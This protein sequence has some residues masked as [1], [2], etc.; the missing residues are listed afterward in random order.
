MKSLGKLLMVMIMFPSPPDDASNDI[1]VSIVQDKHGVEQ[2]LATGQQYSNINKR[3]ASPCEQFTTNL[4]K[5][6]RVHTGTYPKV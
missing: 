1:Y 5:R 4:C 6:S 2:I 3:N